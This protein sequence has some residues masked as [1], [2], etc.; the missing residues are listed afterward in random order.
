MVVRKKV[1]EMVT[2]KEETHKGRISAH[3]VLDKLSTWPTTT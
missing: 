1:R 3:K 2:L